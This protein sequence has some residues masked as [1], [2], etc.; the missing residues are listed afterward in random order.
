MFR[1]GKT[2]LSCPQLYGLV[3]IQSDYFLFMVLDLGVLNKSDTSLTTG[4][5]IRNSIIW[6][7][8]GIPVWSFVY[9]AHEFQWFGIGTRIGQAQSGSQAFTQYLSGYIV[10]LSLSVDNLLYLHWF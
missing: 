1:L 5:A 3:G 8:I 7:S 10:E 4:E 2:P 9:Y 6:V